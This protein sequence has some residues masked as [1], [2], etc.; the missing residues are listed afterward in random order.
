M[1]PEQAQD[2]IAEAKT[3]LGTPYHANAALKG[4]G[5]DCGLFP[6]AV[7]RSQMLIPDYQLPHYSPQHHLHSRE[8]KYISLVEELGGIR[9]D[10]ALP[11]NFI[12]WRIGY[13]F[14]HGGI[15]L[16]WPSVIHSELLRGV[17]LADAMNDG[18]L[19]HRE[20]QIFTL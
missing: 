3:W 4:V 9:T 20:F 11:G 1:S 5:C 13:T 19:A 17:I 15:I 18:D 10:R 7:Y 8:E 16:E 2:L 6:F 12:I 14:A